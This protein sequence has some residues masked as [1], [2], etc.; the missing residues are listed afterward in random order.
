MDTPSN[1]QVLV[2]TPEKPEKCPRHVFS[3]P[4]VSRKSSDVSF[5]EKNFSWGGMVNPVI[6][7]PARMHLID[8]KDFNAFHTEIIE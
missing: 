7:Q 8:E 5:C 2:D 3:G 1:C 6:T 4:G